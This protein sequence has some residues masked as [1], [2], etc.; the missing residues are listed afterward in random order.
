M[1]RGVT[2]N[3]TEYDLGP[4]SERAD[5]PVLVLC[6]ARVDDLVGVRGVSPYGVRVSPAACVPIGAGLGQP[7]VVV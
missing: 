1:D 3:D 7:P 6:E 5:C 2:S 4:C